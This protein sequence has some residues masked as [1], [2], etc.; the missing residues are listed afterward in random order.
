[1]K[2]IGTADPVK[3]LSEAEG[4]YEL[5]NIFGRGRTD[6]MNFC[7]MYIRGELPEYIRKVVQKEEIKIKSATNPT[8][9]KRNGKHGK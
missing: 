7:L 8:R 5:Y 6:E 1:M 4:L 3:I 9:K 2:E